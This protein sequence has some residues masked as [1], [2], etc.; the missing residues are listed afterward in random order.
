MNADEY[1]KERVED[2]IKWY[3]A[4]SKSNQTKYKRWQ[5]V[6]VAAALVIP[7]L[8]LA[9]EC[10]DYIKYIIALLGAF[11]AFAESYIKIY[12]FKD[13]WTKYRIAAEV[14]KREKLF[15]LTNSGVYQGQEK[16]FKIFVQRCEN[17]M[18]SE[19]EEWL[20]IVN[21]DDNTNTE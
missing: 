4:R 21:Q 5:V 11:V 13:L 20:S 16:N 7:V 2:Q 12:D 1:I 14:L 19:N 10:S 3:G 6:K 9:V 18:Q 8:S 17:L 15:F